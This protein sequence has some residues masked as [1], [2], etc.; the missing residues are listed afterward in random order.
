VIFSI[1]LAACSLPVLLLVAAPAVAQTGT[2]SGTVSLEGV[3]LAVR[4]LTVTKNRDVCGKTVQA[5]DVVVSDGKVAYAVASVEGVPGAVRPKTV[6]LSNHDC[7][8]DPPVMAAGAGD[9]IMVDN[10]DPVPH[11]THLGLELG[12]RVRSLGDW[13][14]PAKGSSIRTEGPLR[15][16]GTLDVSCDAH[17]WMSA[18]IVVFDHP[19]FTTSDQAGRFEIKDVPAG[20]HTVKIRHQVL[21]DLEQ[22]VVVKSGATTIMTFAFAAPKI[23]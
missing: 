22:V 5:R 6:V 18:R 3:A 17:P 2:I 1:R 20:T 13:G 8:F 21:G 4:S 15:L 23:R 7:M 16:P 9:T 19:Y 12:M 10:Q 11:K 14:L